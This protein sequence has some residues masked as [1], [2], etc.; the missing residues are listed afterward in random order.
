MTKHGRFTDFMFFLTLMLPLLTVCRP[1]AMGLWTQQK[2]FEG[3]VYFGEILNCHYHSPLLV[4]K[5]ILKGQMETH[6]GKQM[7]PLGPLTFCPYKDQPSADFIFSRILSNSNF[8][9]YKVSEQHL[10]IVHLNA[11][12][13]QYTFII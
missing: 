13:T 1:H 5:Y 11:P 12:C 9:C 10:L 4:Q 6:Y 3:K 7:C 8:S 2:A